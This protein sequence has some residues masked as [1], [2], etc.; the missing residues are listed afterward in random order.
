[1]QMQLRFIC[2]DETTATLAVDPN[3]SVEAVTQRLLTLLEKRNVT[4]NW[5]FLGTPVNP[6]AIIADTSLIDGCTVNVFLRAVSAENHPLP[7]VPVD[8]AAK[9]DQLLL[10]V[11]FAASF[12]VFACASFA[13]TKYPEAFTPFSTI[14]LNVFWSLWAVCLAA[15]WR[16]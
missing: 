11:L 14:A 15:N 1:M 12:V 4:A 6:T 3:E 9:T 10:R 8:Y 7:Q 16:S 5:L 13:R 2:S